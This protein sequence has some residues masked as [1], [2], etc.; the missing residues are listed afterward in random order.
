MYTSFDNNV[1]Y[2]STTLYY[3]DAWYYSAVHNMQ[4]LETAYFPN[5]LFM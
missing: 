1:L 4:T 5:T 3:Q 2:N